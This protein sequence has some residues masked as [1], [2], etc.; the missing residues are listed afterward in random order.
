MPESAEIRIGKKAFITTAIIILCLMILSGVLTQVIPPGSYE[1]VEAEGKV[2]IDPHS[3]HYTEK[4]ALPVYRWFTAPVEVL[5][6]SQNSPV[7]I[8]LSLLILFIGGGYAV[9][10][11]VGVFK[12]II[13]KIVSRFGKKRYLLICIISLVFM[14][15]GS[16]LGMFE[17]VVAL[18][19]LVVILAYNMGWDALIGLGM[20]LLSICFGFAVAIS[21]P[22][23]VG[24]SQRMA[25]LPV[26]SGA[27]FRLLVFAILYALLC[28]FLVRY[29]KGIDGDPR[30]SLVYAEDREM[31]ASFNRPAGD[32]PDL[33]ASDEGRVNKAVAWFLCCFGGILAVIATANLVPWFSDFSMPAIALLYLIAG[34]GAGL[35]GGLRGREVARTFLR[36][37]A[38]VAP[39]I[40][41]I[42]M[43]MSVSYIIEQGG[44]MD[45][46]VHYAAGLIS[47]ASSYLAA[48]LIY[49][50]V[51]VMNFFIGSASAKAAL[52]IPILTPLADLTGLT[53]QTMVLAF[54]FGDGFTNVFY[55]TNGVLLISLGLTTV[56]Y[57][58]WFR[59]IGLL[60]LGVLLITVFM[61]I[62]AVSFGY[63]PF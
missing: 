25:G 63:G 9:L 33:E 23:S 19:P 2:F 21:N 6:A 12:E 51:L 55:P 60:Q 43:A 7:V 44:V 28:F 17:E 38:G 8:V 61:L 18:A 34:V 41:L 42:L 39:G 36:G 32:T 30:R 15:F 37:A 10:N 53:R 54:C 59:W 11:R 58:K 4:S 29:A 45:T 24:L 16:T 13:A 50:L 1:R 49:G 5:Y 47:G 46:V 3:F 48:C 31:R 22:Y 35:W 14:F 26:F 62:L 52:L 57:T 20:S 27:S 56:S 40:I